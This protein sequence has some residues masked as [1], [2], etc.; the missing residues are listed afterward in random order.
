MTGIY[1][2]PDSEEFR[3]DIKKLA[4][5]RDNLIELSSSDVPLKELIALKDKGDS[6]VIN[7]TAYA[8]SVLSTDT[9]NPEY[10]KASAAAEEAAVSY[11]RA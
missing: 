8:D 10:L 1:P 11:Q 3:L 2:S 5:I 4:E 9:E 7:L 6:L